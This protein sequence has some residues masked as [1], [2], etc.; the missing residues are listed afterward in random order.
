MQYFLSTA[1][2]IPDGM[3]FSLFSPL[4]LAWLLLFLAAAVF[5]PCSTGGSPLPA[6]SVPDT[7]SPYC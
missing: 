5:A 2:T 7:Y 1:E 3:G 4:H 6:E